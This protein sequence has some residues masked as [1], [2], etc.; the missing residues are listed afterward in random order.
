MDGLQILIDNISASNNSFVYYLQE[1]ELFEIEHFN[2][3]CEAIILVDEELSF[4]ERGGITGDV[5]SLTTK[6]LYH[7]LNHFNPDN[8]YSIKNLPTNFQEYLNKLDEI[9]YD[10]LYYSL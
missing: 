6:I 10:F 3:M 5:H 2:T 8:L 7:L 9:V 1:K 4:K